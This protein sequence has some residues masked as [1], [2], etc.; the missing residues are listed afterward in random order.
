MSLLFTYDGAIL[1]ILHPHPSIIQH[2][3]TFTL[4]LTSR[5]IIECSLAG[6]C[7]NYMLALDDKPMIRGVEVAVQNMERS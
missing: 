1:L 3:T 2:L 7:V 4:T 6:F 5:P